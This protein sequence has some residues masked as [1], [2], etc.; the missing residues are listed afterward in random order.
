MRLT[1][2]QIA[3]ISAALVKDLTER[4]LI[5]L[6]APAEAAVSAVEKA[7]TAD[8]MVEDR[9]NEEVREILR[10]YQKEIDA[11]RVDYKT[12]YD[13]VKKKLVNDRGLV[14]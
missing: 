11:G 9:L 2:T 7:V 4:G 6:K 3:G 14:I 5:R 10:G 8:L 12:V 13:M 1:K